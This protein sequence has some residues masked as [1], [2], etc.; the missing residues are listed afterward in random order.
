MFFNTDAANAYYLRANSKPVCDV[1]ED[2]YAVS[3]SNGL[4]RGEGRSGV[5]HSLSRDS[6]I[7]QHGRTG[8][9]LRTAYTATTAEEDEGL[10][11]HGHTAAPG[12]LFQLPPSVRPPVA[13][14]VPR[15]SPYSV[16]EP[17][18]V[19]SSGSS[20]ADLLYQARN[21]GHAPATPGSE[22]WTQAAYL[23]CATRFSRPSPPSLSGAIGSSV[24][25]HNAFYQPPAHSSRLP[26]TAEQAS[27][28]AAMTYDAARGGSARS[29]VGVSSSGSHLNRGYH[30]RPSSAPSDHAVALPLSR[31][32]A[33]S[34]FFSG[35]TRLNLHNSFG[36]NT[37]P[38]FPGSPTQPQQRRAP[39][40]PPL[41]L[42]TSS[43]IA[44]RR[45]S[46]GRTG[47]RKSEADSSSRPFL[48]PSSS[49]ARL[50]VSQEPR[51][52]YTAVA[53]HSLMSLE[54]EEDDD[55]ATV[56]RYSAING[57]LAGADRPNRRPVSA[58]VVSEC[59][60]EADD[61]GPELS[62]MN[63]PARVHYNDEVAAEAAEDEAQRANSGSDDAPR[64]PWWTVDV[65]LTFLAGYYNSPAEEAEAMLAAATTRPPA[66]MHVVRS[67]QCRAPILPADTTLEEAWEMTQSF[68]RCV[69][70]SAVEGTAIA[71]FPCS[72]QAYYYFDQDFNQYVQL[73]ADTL[74]LA[75]TVIRVVMVASSTEL[76]PSQEAE[77]RVVTASAE[78][79]TRPSYPRHQQST[80]R[81][82]L[83]ATSSNQQQYVMPLD[84][85]SR[86][87][88]REPSGPPRRRRLPFESDAEDFSPV[89]VPVPQP[90]QQDFVRQQ[91]QQ[92][93]AEYAYS[94]S[95]NRPPPHSQGQY[96]EEGGDAYVDADYH[97][98]DAVPYQV[99][100]GQ[101]AQQQQL[102]GLQHF[103]EVW[104]MVQSSYE[105]LADYSIDANAAAMVDK[106]LRASYPVSQ[107][108][109]RFRNVPSPPLRRRGSA[110]Y[111]GSAPQRAP[112]HRSW[113]G[114]GGSWD[115]PA[116]RAEGGSGVTRSALMPSMQPPPQPHPPS[117]QAPAPP[118]KRPVPQF[119][120]DPIL[121][122]STASSLQPAP[123]STSWLHTGLTDSFV[124]RGASQTSM[125]TPTPPRSSPTLHLAHRLSSHPYYE[126]F[127]AVPPPPSHGATSITTFAS[128]SQLQRHAG[129]S[130][131]SFSGS[132]DALGA[133]L[134]RSAEAMRSKS[135][136]TTSSSE[137]ATQV[138]SAANMAKT[139][140]AVV[141]EKALPSPLPASS[142]DDG[143]GEAGNSAMGEV[144]K[145]ASLVEDSAAME[146]V[147]AIA[148]HKTTATAAAAAGAPPPHHV[149]VT[150]SPPR[151]HRHDHEQ[152]SHE[153]DEGAVK[154]EAEA[155]LRLVPGPGT[156][157][158]APAV[159]LEVAKAN[160]SGFHPV[161]V[162]VK[163][164]EACPGEDA[165]ALLRTLPN[166]AQLPSPEEEEAAQKAT[167][168]PGEMGSSAP[169]TAGT[170]S[171]PAGI[172]AVAVDGFAG[173]SVAHA[174]TVDAG[175]SNDDDDNEEAGMQHVNSSS[176]VGKGMQLIRL[177]R[178]T[179]A[180]GASVPRTLTRT[181]AS[182]QFAEAAAEEEERGGEEGIDAR[183][184][185]MPESRV[186]PRFAPNVAPSAARRAAA[187]ESLEDDR[188]DI[189]NMESAAAGHDAAAVGL[190]NNGNPASAPRADGP[191]EVAGAEAYAQKAV[192]GVMA[193]AEALD[194]AVPVAEKEGVAQELYSSDVMDASTREAENHTDADD[195]SEARLKASTSKTATDEV[196]PAPHAE[197]AVAEVDE[198]KNGSEEDVE[199]E[200][201]GDH[202]DG[203]AEQR[204][205]E[206][207]E[208]E[209][210]LAE[211]E[212]REEAAVEDDEPR[213]DTPKSKEEASEVEP[214]KPKQRQWSSSL[215]DE[216][217]APSYS[218]AEDYEDDGANE[219]A[220]VV[221]PRTPSEP[222]DKEANESAA[223]EPP[224]AEE[225]VESHGEG[226]HA[227][228]TPAAE[229]EKG[230]D[231]DENSNA[232][233]AF[234]LLSEEEEK[235]A[236]DSVT[237]AEVVRE[238][239]LDQDEAVFH[240]TRVL[241]Q[242]ESTPAEAEVVV[243]PVAD[244]AAVWPISNRRPAAADYPV[245]VFTPP[246]P[247]MLK[248]NIDDESK[249][250]PRPMD[251]EA[252]LLN[253]SAG[254]HQDDAFDD[255]ALS[256][257]ADTAQL[258]DL[259]A[260]LPTDLAEFGC[261]HND[262]AAPVAEA[263]A[264]N[265][266]TELVG[267]VSAQDESA[268]E[269]E[270]AATAKA[271]QAEAKTDDVHG[272][273]AENGDDREKEEEEEEEHDRPKEEDSVE[274]AMPCG[275][276][277]E[278]AAVK[279]SSGEAEHAAAAEQKSERVVPALAPTTHEASNRAYSATV[280][281]SAVEPSPNFAAV[282]MRDSS[283]PKGHS[284]APLV[285]DNV[286][287]Y[288][289]VT[290]LHTG[291]AEQLSR[292]QDDMDAPPMFHRSG[293]GMAGTAGASAS[294]STSASVSV[295][296]AGQMN[297]TISSSGAGIPMWAT[298]D[299]PP[300]P[301]L[302]SHCR[303]D[304]AGMD[305]EAEDM[306]HHKTTT[307]THGNDGE[308]AVTDAPMNTFRDS[309]SI[310]PTPTLTR[311]EEEEDTSGTG[312]ASTEDV[313]KMLVR[314][315]SS[316]AGMPPEMAA[317]TQ[318]RAARKSV[319][320]ARHSETR[321]E[322]AAA[323]DVGAPAAP[324]KTPSP[325]LSAALKGENE[326]EEENFTRAVTEASS[327]TQTPETTKTQP[328]TMFA[329]AAQ[330]PLTSVI[331]VAKPGDRVA[332]T[333]QQQNVPPSPPA[334]VAEAEADTPLPLP[335][336][337]QP[338][339]PAAP[340]DDGG[341]RKTMVLLGFPGSAWEYVMTY[342]YEPMHEAF[343][344]DAAAAANVPHSAIQDVRYSKGS[345]MVDLYV[346]HSTSVGE[347][348]LRDAMCNYEYPHLWAL[349]EEKK[350][351]RK[352]L[353]HGE[354][355]SGIL[356]RSRHTALSAEEE[357]KWS[358]HA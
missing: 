300:P 229:D 326:A 51:D 353:L 162:P 33:S 333:Q 44:S 13:G 12:R 356:R 179:V 184:G 198:V 260:D 68:L 349:Y 72:P 17:G 79:L 331:S 167:A 211:E 159:Q 155:A 27:A 69:A 43:N 207:E 335:L 305:D 330:S 156:A 71:D 52:R 188:L 182:E 163:A 299:V 165:A 213:S 135:K 320:S 269:S 53:H 228:P 220:P 266:D 223:E 210:H 183:L 256:A 30:Q 59:W 160:T 63:E 118:A 1:E 76:S 329:A 224:M 19:G 236:V 340:H 354:G 42:H 291:S 153:N 169:P 186:N 8:S 166:S 237:P 199:E 201:E 23:P 95:C 259:T 164:M 258:T 93:V 264:L 190:D 234:F 6:R 352:K 144:E 134:R 297:A 101:Q 214:S 108:M 293:A 298:A 61:A 304:A 142:T 243:A 125:L 85:N 191:E 74:A 26:A 203:D 152:H 321:E 58:N 185:T 29:S 32:N 317:A 279:Q 217:S 46:E 73:N 62:N 205:S 107:R 109:Q 77:T 283:S 227:P 262:T 251:A 187:A 150:A 208:L 204:A 141:L 128:A 4:A 124:S 36:D 84:K 288:S 126:E 242:S 96:E 180:S 296:A 5:P 98:Y 103:A 281:N 173:R 309:L 121:Q 92:E 343:I 146:V 102:Q 346:L 355:V 341:M 40:A 238:A 25:G 2:L 302:H 336:L 117:R 64:A 301:L 116:G 307:P 148:Q 3:A 75:S 339:P 189:R 274:L 119:F 294:A 113:A 328:G 21:R 39:A 225:E 87:S 49:A 268:A 254:S 197:H 272:E 138:Y 200:A 157:V 327:A 285:L 244:T 358:P 275:E 216:K 325:S 37:R 176:V 202:E 319:D 277:A 35:A 248:G 249:R 9:P 133:L 57:V 332:D 104:D 154:R 171:A 303:L 120:D 351:E 136:G 11:E 344:N 34:V 290:G 140:V 110:P 347:Q 147:T 161:D 221:P 284:P 345:L 149:H 276:E 323:V 295:S 240:E 111:R 20:G 257:A 308:D 18:A 270:A 232:P 348:E 178:N 50:R 89:P 45:S 132:Y 230:N 265:N 253:T 97:G 143:V 174:I 67:V 10:E 14:T 318:A 78:M 357:V 247:P 151:S 94:A 278:E 83:P 114:Y 271:E 212:E 16:A 306:S 282:D 48:P 334:A 130:L 313:A 172:A 267:A 177:E 209:Q 261:S 139:A 105:E 80:T 194:E 47:A 70:L 60:D 280:G 127:L 246:P 99:V 131:S 233:G 342:H 273:M 263:K 338:Q 235:A 245:E 311:K 129:A 314:I 100:Y 28:S 215:R 218:S 41:Q 15:R 289:G 315:G 170:A 181:Q 123:L 241:Q 91:Q 255:T 312:M 316:L 196:V 55:G 239:E 192:A 22:V 168:D 56:T 219:R 195:A 193:E 158:V 175:S 222:S 226:Q 88:S 286:D 115:A 90:R 31:A 112:A 287:Y 24:S 292:L 337:M 350:R 106:Q 206:N 7:D 38:V 322:K 252:S 137:Q 82:G 250:S 66:D 324:A 65:T 310:T 122:R 231:D 145:L 54:E 86:A 81:P